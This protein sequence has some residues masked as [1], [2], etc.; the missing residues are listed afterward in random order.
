MEVLMVTDTMESVL[1]VP[2]RSVYYAT[3]LGIVESKEE[4]KTKFDFDYVLYSSEVDDFLAQHQV[5]VLYTTQGTNVSF[6]G[7]H[8]LF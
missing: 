7:I 6:T 3:W 2:K 5:D 8:L 1:I 4:M